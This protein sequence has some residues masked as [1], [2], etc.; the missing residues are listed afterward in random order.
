M[1]RI[2]ERAFA[3]RQMHELDPREIPDET[4]VDRI[5]ASERIT[6]V[7][8]CWPMRGRLKE[9]YLGGVV[10]LRAGLSPG[11]RCW[12]K[13]HALYHHLED[14]GNEIHLDAV[15]HIGMRQSERRAEVFTGWLL[16]GE[17]WRGRDGWEIAELSGLPEQRIARWLRLKG[18]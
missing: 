4:L 2:A 3:L 13:A 6:D 1:Q 14:D 11:E 5:L 8:E 12:L 16:L 10:F 18:N 9:V 15:S 7:L 17:S